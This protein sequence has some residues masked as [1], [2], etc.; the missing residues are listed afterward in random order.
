MHVL[1]VQHSH[2][3]PLAIP[4]S[5]RVATRLLLA[6]AA[7]FACC[8]A[9]QASAAAPALA[10]LPP[11]LTANLDG[12]FGPVLRTSLKGGSLSRLRLGRAATAPTIDF[13]LYVYLCLQRQ[14]SHRGAQQWPGGCQC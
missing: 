1:N 9:L 6:A 14:S 3:N 13:V 11:R 12:L 4:S 5:M 7:G 10:L 2:M 8:D